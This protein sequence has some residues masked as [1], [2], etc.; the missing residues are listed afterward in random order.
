MLHTQ[1]VPRL[2]YF[3]KKKYFHASHPT[4]PVAAG[5]GAQQSPTYVCMIKKVSIFAKKRVSLLCPF[6]FC[7]YEVLLLVSSAP[8]SIGALYVYLCI[9]GE[10]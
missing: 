4:R 5:S 7:P 2:F 1:L 3:L 6:V 10:N 8:N 9:Y